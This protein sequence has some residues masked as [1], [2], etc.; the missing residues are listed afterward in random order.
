MVFSLFQKEYK[1]SLK[2]GHSRRM[3]LSFHTLFAYKAGCT[4]GISEPGNNVFFIVLEQLDKNM[5]SPVWET[6]RFLK[7]QKRQVSACFHVA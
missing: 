4:F 7:A 1:F 3:Q 5:F 2:P 6:A